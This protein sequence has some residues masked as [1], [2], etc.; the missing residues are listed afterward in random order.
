[1]NRSAFLGLG[2]A[3]VVGCT[4]PR[5]NATATLYDIDAS[6]EPLRTAFNKDAHNVRILMLVSPT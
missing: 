2:A 1:M 6:G 3:A 4:A 5:A